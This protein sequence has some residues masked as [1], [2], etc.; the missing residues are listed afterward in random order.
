MAAAEPGGAERLTWPGGISE[1][2][3]RLALGGKPLQNL[4]TRMSE[5]DE[6]QRGH[7]DPYRGEDS[8]GS[9]D[10]DRIGTCGAGSGF[11]V[12]PSCYAQEPMKARRHEAGQ[13]ARTT[14]NEHEGKAKTLVTASST[15]SAQT[16]GR[17]TIYQEADGKLVL[18]LTS[19]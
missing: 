15:E 8:N 7:R 2:A 17:A 10:Q 1:H 9:D 19:F 16:E 11:S 14:K 13:D 18:R 3:K 12:Q 5:R 6:S 4:W